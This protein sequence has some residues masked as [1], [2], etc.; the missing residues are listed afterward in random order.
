MPCLAF[1]GLA[2]PRPAYPCL[3]LPCLACPVQSFLGLFWPNPHRKRRSQICVGA[4]CPCGQAPDARVSPSGRRRRFK[5]SG[6]C[7]PTARAEIVRR[8]GPYDSQK[9]GPNRPTDLALP[10]LALPRLALP[11][12]ASMQSFLGFFLPPPLRK[13]R[14]TN[15]KRGAGRFCVGRSGP[16]A[17]CQNGRFLFFSSIS[18]GKNVHFW[19]TA[20]RSWGPYD[21]W[22]MGR[23]RLA[24]RR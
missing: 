12:L 24:R 6:I 2:S 15:T 16:D 20:V 22:R 1:P 17:F 9:R 4:V 11:C 3:A 21:P 19:P 23:N 13:G 18:L 10:R 14:R 5:S 8:G 7:Y